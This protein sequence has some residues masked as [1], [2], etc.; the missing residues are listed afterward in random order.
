[1]IFN[2]QNRIT[3]IGTGTSTGIPIIGCLCNVCTSLDHRD[4][5]LRTSIYVETRNG[6][7]FLVDTTP[8]LRTQFLRNKISEL[9]FVLITHE[10]ADHLHGIDDLRPFGFKSSNKSIPIYTT[11]KTQQIIENRFDYIFKSRTPGATIG[12]GIPRLYLNDVPLN[13]NIVIEGEEFYFFTYSH[14][15]CETMGFIHEQ[16]AYIVDCHNL[17]DKILDE[18]RKRKLKLLIIDCVQNAPHSTHLCVTKTFEYIKQIKPAQAG[19]IHMGH[20]LGHQALLNIAKKEFGDHV[21]PLYDQQ[22]LFY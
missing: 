12:G 18:L 11:L 1:M 8:D 15:H 2:N 4:Q 16:M 14:G 21:F 17:S 19:L 20:D 10:H 13:Q 5:R 6:K 9:D 7:K 3:A 22:S